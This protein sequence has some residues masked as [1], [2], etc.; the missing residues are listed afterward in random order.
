MGDLDASALAMHE[1]PAHRAAKNRAFDLRP[2][3]GI[4]IQRRSGV[5][6]LPAGDRAAMQLDE[7]GE[8]GGDSAAEL[9]PAVLEQRPFEVG[10]SGQLN[11]MSPAEFLAFD[12]VEGAVGEVDVS[13]NL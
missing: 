6:G 1:I 7:A 8:R 3:A 2:G 12:V 4:D 5:R 10:A 11:L 13:S 9:G